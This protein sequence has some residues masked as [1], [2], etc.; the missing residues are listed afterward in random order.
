MRREAP[1]YYDE[2]PTSGASPATTTCSPS[3]RTRRRSR[4]GGRRGRTATPLPMMISMDD[5]DHQRRR[6]LVNRG[7][8]A[9][10]ASPSM[11]D[12]GRRAVPPRSSTGCASAGACDFVWDVAAP[13]PLLLIA[14]LLGFDEDAHDD[15]LRWSDDLIRATD[16]RPVAR[17]RRGRAAGHARLPRA[18]SSRVIAERRADAPRRPH[19]H[20]VPRRDR[21]ATGSTTS[22]SCNET[23]LHPH[24]RRRDDP[25]R[26]QRR[27]ARPARAPRPAARRCAD[28]PG[29]APGRRSRSCCAGCRR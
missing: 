21:R 10:G 18:A 20:A 27:H 13:L 7:L 3:R 22:R 25:P 23:L 2:A 6:S 4:A 19:Q 1:V 16:A 24:R 15:L 14:D 28:D 26:H 8:H 12:D 9:R 17:G 5:P 11:E 29:A